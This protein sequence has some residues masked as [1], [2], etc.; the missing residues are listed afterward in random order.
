MRPN[1]KVLPKI[2]LLLGLLALVSLAVTVFS[3]QRMRLIDDT[4][5]ELIDGPGKANLAIARAN[6]NLVSISRSIYRLIAEETEDS[7]QQALKELADSGAFFHKQ[8]K[9]ATLAMPARAME[10]RQIAEAVDAAMNKTCA[11][12][13][14]LAKSIRPADKKA[15]AMSMRENCDPAINEAMLSISAL[16]NRILESNDEVSE[17]ALSV[18]NSTIRN[19]YLFV[20]GGLAIVLLFV[21][22]RIEAEQKLGHFAR[23]DALTGLPNRV[24]FHERMDAALARARRGEKFA[25][26]CL[27]LDRFKEVNDTLGHPVGDKLLVEVCARLRAQLRETD[28]LARLGGDEFAIVQSHLTS[29]NDSS[30]FA[31]RLIDSI[32]EPYEID[33]HTLVVGVSVGI[34]VAPEDGEHYEDLF[35]AADMALYRAKAEGRGAWRWFE[36]EMNER[37]QRRRTVEVDL[38]HALEHNEFEL[39]YQP[40]VE[41]ATRRIKSFEALIRWRHPE[42]GLIPSDSFIPLCEEIGL[43]APLGAW[44]LRQACAEAACWP[45]SL[46]VAVNITSLQFPGRKLVETVELALMYSGLAPQR[47]EVEITETAVLQNAEATLVILRDLKKLGVRIA[48]VDFGAGYSSL[49]SLQSFPFDK[50][51]IDRS[52]TRE[53]DQSRKNDVIVTAMTDLCVGLEICATAEGVETEAQLASLL[54]RGCGEAQGFLFSRPCPAG[55]IPALITQMGVFAD[56]PQAAE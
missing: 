51:K 31:Q 44:V 1:L 55:D 43:I 24:L 23:H 7:M 21:A 10:F 41:T 47:L 22:I 15:A 27:D 16:T 13:I 33:G 53:L 28:T 2:L 5:G 29:P 39:F 11:P 52:F 25:L 49:S 34:A 46:G 18:T 45:G 36:P 26:L 38:R 40:I 30:F 32:S 20:I 48:M 3:T 17:A 56:W 54:R 9:I 50:I 35:K 14:A 6:R 4:Y 19:T 8:V 37:M 12:T 42:R